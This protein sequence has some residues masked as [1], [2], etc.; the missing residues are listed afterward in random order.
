MIQKPFNCAC[1]E[2]CAICISLLS[3]WH[4]LCMVGGSV[5]LHYSFVAPYLLVSVADVMFICKP[6]R[7]EAWDGECGGFYRGGQFGP[8]LPVFFPEKVLLICRLLA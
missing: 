6:L 4:V 7:Q 2:P 1:T 3:S 8:G 5:A